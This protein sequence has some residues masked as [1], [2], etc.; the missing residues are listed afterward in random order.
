MKCIY[1]DTE[2]LNAHVKDEIVIGHCLK[3]VSEVDIIVAPVVSVV[4]SQQ[5]Q[6]RSPD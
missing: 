2:Y 1:T 5:F 3:K 4:A 6:I